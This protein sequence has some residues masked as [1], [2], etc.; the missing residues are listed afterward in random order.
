PKI[1]QSVQSLLDVYQQPFVLVDRNFNIVAS[2]KA[3]AEQYNLE[4][5]DI[6]G[7]KCHKISHHSDKPCAEVGEDCPH[8]R[9]FKS[10]H[11]EEALHVHTR[12]DGTK[13]CVEIK[14]HPIRGD[15]GEILYMGEHLRPIETHDMLDKNE[16]VGSSEPFLDA[17]REAS[18]LAPSSLPALITGESGVGKEK[19]A[20]YIH[21]RS[22]RADGPFITLDCCGLNETLFESELFGHEA[23]SF[24]GAHK[25]KKGLFEIANGGTL[26]LDEIG[27]IS[28]T[29]QAKLLRVIETGEYRPVGSN[30]TS[31]A[32]VRIVS[33]TNRNLLEMV[34]E[35]AFRRDLYH[36]L[37]GHTVSLPPLRKRK[38]DIPVLLCYFMQDMDKKSAPTGDTLRL[39]EQYKYPG[40]I[41]E[42]KY[43]VELAAL[44][45]VDGH[46]YPEHL[47]DAVRY[48]RSEQHLPAKEQPQQRQDN[49]AEDAARGI[50]RQD[51]QVVMGQ[52]TQTVLDALQACRGSR[53]AA[54]RELG[55]SERKIY[56]LLKRYQQ[57]GLYV[58]S[59]YQ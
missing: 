24:T 35:G 26:F 9:M 21:K 41:R 46:M 38:S 59:P 48:Q 28:L 30:Q 37:A 2:N 17:V 31:Q 53:R 50:R 13:D 27:E 14:A 11:V 36:R 12:P 52:N 1:P 45:A 20:A 40:N 43:I 44:K 7:C 8:R 22:L 3:Y 29:L 5:E 58:P 54:A 15:D 42:L 6:V 19:F 34:D 57:M 10:G 55:I 51:D 47:P 56:R 33:A 23:G 39:L 49:G 18:M 32:D 4:P 25:Q 16:L